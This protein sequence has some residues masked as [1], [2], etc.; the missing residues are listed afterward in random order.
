MQSQRKLHFGNSVLRFIFVGVSI[1]LQ[2]CWILMTILVLNESVPWLELL[3]H[4]LS[5]A[6]VLQ[7]NSKHTDAAYKMPWIMLIVAFPV[8]G[9]SLYLMIG[10]FGDLGSIGKRMK[11]ARKI[12]R[13]LLPDNEDCAERLLRQALPAA[14]LGKYLQK[15]AACPVYE[16]TAVAYY[17]EAH[18]AF[19][20]LKA[21]LEKA[22]SFIFMEYFIVSGDSSFQELADILIRKAH[23]GVDVRFMYD[24]VGS[25][26]YVNLTF[27][28]RLSDAGIHC[29]VFNPALPFLNLFMNHRDHR[30]I[31]V[32]DGKV[33]FTGGYNLAD[34]YFGRKITYGRWKDTGIR[35]E[36]EAVQSLTAAFLE[37]WN[38]CSRKQEPMDDFLS[39]RHCVPTARGFVQPYEDNPLSRER[40]A[41]SVYLNLIYAARETLYVTTPY[42]I[43]TDEMTNALGLAAKRGVDVR[44]ITPGI[45]DKKIIYAVTRSYYAGL[46][47]QGVRIFEY[48]PGFCHAKQMLCDGKTA[49]IGTSNLDYRSLYLHFENNVLLYGGEAVEKMAVEF[50]ILFSQ[51]EEVTEKYRSGRSKA[52]RI[53]QYILRLFAPLL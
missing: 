29:M 41:E 9:L 15:Q 53:G 18:D 49:S 30:K 3:A 28:K 16:N 2:V 11:S 12:T 21:D 47:A 1:L 19:D 20:A 32:I 17:A 10:I 24:D 5:V 52:L 42:L 23:E 40:T 13:A 4:L 43:I 39:V 25:V 8:M 44:I 6:V 22:E 27:A 35:L 51:C 36:G 38:A 46:A 7:L 50:D 31:T 45:P 37:I 48:T 14:G 33:G 34:E 26:G